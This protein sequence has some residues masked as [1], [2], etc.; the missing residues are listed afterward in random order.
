MMVRFEGNRDGRVAC[1]DQAG[2]GVHEI[3]AAEGQPDVVENGVCLECREVAADGVLDEIDQP[4]GLLDA[5][6]GFGTQMED[7]LTA[8]GTAEEV[9]AYPRH[10]S[11]APDASYQ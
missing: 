10:Q 5:R 9:L 11:E 3:D 1:A 4:G 2:G 8:I 6:T 7:E